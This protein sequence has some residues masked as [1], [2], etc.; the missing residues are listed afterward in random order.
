[1]MCNPHRNLGFQLN[2]VYAGLFVYLRI[3]KSVKSA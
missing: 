2:L 3:F 1:M